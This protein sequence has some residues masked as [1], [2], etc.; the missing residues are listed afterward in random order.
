MIPPK[1]G[2]NLIFVMLENWIGLEN[3]MFMQRRHTII[4][5]WRGVYFS[6][7]RPRV[8]SPKVPDEFLLNL[9]VSAYPENFPYRSNTTSILCK[10]QVDILMWIVVLWVVVS[11]HLVSG[12][13]LSGGCPEG[14]GIFDLVN[15]SGN[16]RNI[17][18]CYTNAVFYKRM[19]LQ[20][21]NCDKLTLMAM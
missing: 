6:P 14:A 2:V 5:Y 1:D 17:I 10:N 7:V 13:E 11:R 18:F 15:I 20:I 16:T 4:M 9:V 21:C 12:S 3:Q 19:K 8:F